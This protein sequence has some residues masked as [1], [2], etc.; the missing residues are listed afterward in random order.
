MNLREWSLRRWLLAIA[1]VILLPVIGLRLQLKWRLHRAIEALRESGMPVTYGDL[2]SQQGVI[3]DASNMVVAL[4]NVMRRLPE[5]D[6]TEL[7][8]LPVIGMKPTPRPGVPWPGE[9]ADATRNY[10]SAHREVFSEV[11]A[12]IAITNAWWWADYNPEQWQRWGIVDAK[13]ASSHLALE[14]AY[15][16]QAGNVEEAMR[17]VQAI[18]DLAERM[19]RD[20]IL[21][22]HL[23]RGAIQRTALNQLEYVINCGRPSA[24]TLAQMQA[25]LKRQM[26]QV[27]LTRVY[28]GERVFFLE[29]AYFRSQRMVF[30]LA[31]A[32]PGPGT[33]EDYVQ[34]VSVFGYRLSGLADQDILDGIHLIQ[35]IAGRAGTLPG[36]IDLEQNWAQLLSAGWGHGFHLWSEQ[37][38]MTSGPNFLKR[39]IE[40]HGLLRA[41]DAALAVERYRRGH[42]GKL[43]ESLDALVPEFLEAVPVEPRSDKPFELIK[44]ADGFG[45]GRGTPV[46]KVLSSEVRQEPRPA[47]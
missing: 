15:L 8:L 10:L 21:I 43:P 7:D 31:M 27:S 26:D 45:I 2:Y 5:L 20:P 46:F 30:G 12:A 25:V 4:T 42:T 11:R 22:T 6:Q 35:D 38:I 29:P 41:A 18:F 3:P 24:G 23:V 44:T 37:T 19:Y 33:L 16:A 1:A 9:M 34:R 13:S 14:A 17:S 39:P 36:Q 40:N 47:R 28:E 32:E